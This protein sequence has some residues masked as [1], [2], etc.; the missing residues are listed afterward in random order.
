MIL[1]RKQLLWLHLALLLTSSL[2]Q[3]RMASLKIHS[4]YAMKK[5]FS[6]FLQYNVSWMYRTFRVEYFS[7]YRIVLY[8][9]RTASSSTVCIS[10]CFLI[11]LYISISFLRRISKCITRYLRFFNIYF[12]FIYLN[13]FGLK[14]M[15]KRNGKLVSLFWVY[16]LHKD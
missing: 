14:T 2:C 13:T 9:W 1:C 4:S 12:S 16:Q 15:K 3:K 8:K 6:L 11:L 10:V 5:K 7:I